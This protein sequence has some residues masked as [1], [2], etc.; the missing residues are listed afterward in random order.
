MDPWRLGLSAS[1]VTVVVRELAAALV[2]PEW[3]GLRPAHDKSAI[4]TARDNVFAIVEPST[5]YEV[6][7]I[8]ASVLTAVAGG[9]ALR[10]CPA[11]IDGWGLSGAAIDLA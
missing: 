3:I 10:L 5:A 11:P 8:I 9:S 6:L 4:A 2:W 1:R 7:G